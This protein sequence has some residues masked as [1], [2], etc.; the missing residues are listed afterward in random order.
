MFTVLDSEGS[1]VIDLGARANI[2]K[3]VKETLADP[4]PATSGTGQRVPRQ[5]KELKIPA[6]VTLVAEP[7]DHAAILNITASDRPGFLATIALVLVEVGLEI[8][9]ARITTL[10]ERVEDVFVVVSKKGESLHNG[11]RCYEIE[12]TIR[13]RLDQAI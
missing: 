2:I 7:H 3:R 5:L 9:S 10:G 13:Q 11:Q 6:S 4:E 8:M 1:E 12:Q